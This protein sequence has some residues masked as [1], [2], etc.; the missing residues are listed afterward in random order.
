MDVTIYDFS[1]GVCKFSILS[2]MGMGM[3]M[4]MRKGRESIEVKN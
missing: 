2:R 4:G 1:R 3:G